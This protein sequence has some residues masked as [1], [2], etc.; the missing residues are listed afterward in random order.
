[1]HRT[2]AAIISGNA[3]K[4]MRAG[5]GTIPTWKYPVHIRNYD[6]FFQWQN[7]RYKIQKN[8]KSRPFIASVV[9]HMSDSC[10]GP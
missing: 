6:K 4:S 9:F 7:T 3:R 10:V 2:Q 1:M 8:I 5:F